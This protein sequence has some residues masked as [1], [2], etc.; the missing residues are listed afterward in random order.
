MPVVARFCSPLTGSERPFT[1]QQFEY[2][3]RLVDVMDTKAHLSTLD[4]IVGVFLSCGKIDKAVNYTKIMY[5]DMKNHCPQEKQFAGLVM[6]VMLFLCSGVFG[7]QD[8]VEIMRR[9][10]KDLDFKQYAGVFTKN[11]WEKIHTYVNERLLHKNGTRMSK[12][13]VCCYPNLCVLT[14]MMCLLLSGKGF[15]KI[16]KMVSRLFDGN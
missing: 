14:K 12:I 7:T 5:E 6:N 2:F 15:T 3:E 4:V 9:F 1:P 10:M 13:Y 16:Q 8:K 11:S